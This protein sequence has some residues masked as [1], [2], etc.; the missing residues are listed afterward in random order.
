MISVSLIANTDLKNADEFKQLV[1]AQ[2][3]GA[4]VHLSDVADVTLGQRPMM[5]RSV[6]AVRKRPSWAL[7]AAYFQYDRGDHS[8]AGAFPGIESRLPAGLKA[9][10]AY[11]ATL[12]IEDALHEIVKTLLE[13]LCIVVAVIFLFMGSFGPF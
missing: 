7:G 11:D 9:T 8:S 12:Y 1:V 10:V 6:S 4:I 5:T 13:T 2:R 3:N